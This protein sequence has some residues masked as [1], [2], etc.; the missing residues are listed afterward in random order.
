MQEGHAN[1]VVEAEAHSD[2]VVEAN[3]EGHAGIVIEVEAEGFASCRHS[4]RSMQKD[5]QT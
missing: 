1:V 5:M 3:A 2:I 4:N